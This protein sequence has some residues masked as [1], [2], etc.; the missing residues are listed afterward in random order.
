[1]TVSGTDTDTNQVGLEVPSPT[2]LTATRVLY[3]AA[4][5]AIAMV[6][7]A[8]LVLQLKF[9]IIQVFAAVIVAA[10]MA[11]LVARATD[12]QRAHIFGWRPPKAVVVVLIYLVIGVLLVVVGSIMISVALD[13]LN[14][15]VTRAPEYAATIE[16]WLADLQATSPVLADLH[17][18]DVF[19]GAS[20]ISQTLSRVLGQLL[21]AA[22]VL[23]TIFGGA[24]NVLFV[25]F[26]ALYMTVDG[27]KILNYVIV[28]FPLSRQPQSRR[29]MTNIVD[30]LS[31]WVV[32]QLLLAL[33]IG[34]VAG[35]G[36]GLLGVPGAPVLG[37]IWLIA[38][39]IPGIGPFIAAVPS[40][41]MGFL[42][43]PTTGVLATIFT[44]AWSQ[45]ESNVVTPRLMGRAV[46]I[47]S[48]V[49][50]VALLVGNELLG[51]VGALFAIPAAAAIA[52][53]VD[54]LR[55]QRLEYLDK[56]RQFGA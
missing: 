48:L 12:P 4:I 37:M 2:E 16:S 19:G 18:V 1:M 14:S 39:F 49:V 50:L 27:E 56:Q 40:I 28:F 15:L 53:I 13:G 10:G 43:G 6:A 52:V 38:E 11:P 34:T 17:L 8:L 55:K 7:L 31:H 30:R 21:G 29:V 32:G 22:S 33:V 35:I 47:N 36:L 51:L 42:A 9:V 54:E 45:I 3:R 25:L 41:L 44:L 24:V 23:F 20:G 26:M 5:F 46:Q